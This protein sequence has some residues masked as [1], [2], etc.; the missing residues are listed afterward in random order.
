M[1]SK[2]RGKKA[3]VSN[4]NTANNANVIEDPSTTV[5]KKSRSSK[6][7]PPVVAFVSPNGITGSFM[8]EQRPLIAH[9]PVSSV[10]VAFD[11]ANIMKYDPIVP[12]VPKA[13][14][15]KQDLSYLDGIP[16]G[17]G[18]CSDVQITKATIMN[19]IKPI[20]TESNVI[21]PQEIQT[22]DQNKTNPSTK[23]KLPSYYS[24][25][26]MVLF[27]DANR[28]QK[29]PERTD[30]ACYWC[31]HSFTTHPCAIPRHIMDEVWYMYGNFCSPECAAS[32]LF[33]ER[34]DNHVQWER[35]A[36]LNC[37][38]SDDV[39]MKPNSSS[40][41][42]PAPPR[43][44]LRMFGGT[45]D[46][47]EYRALVHEKRLRVDVMTPPMVSIVQTMDTKP[48]DF[49]DQNIKNVFARG[50]IQHKYNAPG[51]QGLRLRRTKPLKSRESTV[52]WAMQIQQVMS[53]ATPA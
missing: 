17:S 18:V 26:L 11:G 41:I 6:K 32:Y 22:N 21:E 19:E 1:S 24:E 16:E 3:A 25:K 23:C 8:N 13:Y 30:I 42:R 33:K 28:Y 51:A 10:S 5:P 50:D 7:T 44:I 43:E 9:I 46:I 34:I 4:T 40:G 47:N 37:L 52:E 45:M 38:Y 20:T 2:P 29:L 31:C 48:I 39:E 53:S 36:L 35:Y 14:D 49:Y 27:Q 12:E 15:S